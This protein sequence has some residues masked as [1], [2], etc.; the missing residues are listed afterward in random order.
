MTTNELIAKMKAD[1][2]LLREKPLALAA[3]S[4]HSMVAER[5]FEKGQ[6]AGD[7]KIGD[8]NNSKKIYVN[9]K[10]SPKKFTAKGKSGKTKFK[11]GNSHKTG[12]FDSYKSFRQKIGR[13][14]AFV[15]LKLSGQL[16]KDFTNSLQ[17]SSGY[18]ISGVKNKANVGKVEGAEDKYKNI[19]KLT[20]KESSEIK[21][22]ASAEALKILNNA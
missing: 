2:R 11:N 5:I 16:Q 8:Y 15:D 17:K 13:Q 3:F 19:F 22:I 21:R 9:P 4:V 18:W 7:G 14:T 6:N 1:V 10:I 20:K 12:F